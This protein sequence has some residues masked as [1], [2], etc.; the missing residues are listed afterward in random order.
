MHVITYMVNLLYL[1]GSGTGYDDALLGHIRRHD[2]I[3]YI[4]YTSVIE[5]LYGQVLSY[6]VSVLTQVT[7]NLE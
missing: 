1:F 5:S 6:W 2:H 4:E 7:G 3:L